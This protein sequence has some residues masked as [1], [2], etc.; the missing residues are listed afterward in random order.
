MLPLHFW[1]I[2][3]RKLMVNAVVEVEI[4]ELLVF[5]IR[6]SRHLAVLDFAGV[7]DRGELCKGDTVVDFVLLVQCVERA[8]HNRFG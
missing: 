1:L 4:V 6:S 2:F 8:E 5:S 7:E 3:I